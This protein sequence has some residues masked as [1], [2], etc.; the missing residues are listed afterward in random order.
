M[1]VSGVR[2]CVTA[3]RNHNSLLGSI[4]HSTILILFFFMAPLCKNNLKVGC[5]VCLFFF[6]V[7]LYQACMQTDT[8]THAHSLPCFIS[9]PLHCA[10]SPMMQQGPGMAYEGLGIAREACESHSALQTSTSKNLVA[11]R[12]RDSVSL[13]VPPPQ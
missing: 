5:P 8:H 10:Q 11:S 4:S 7:Y 3:D 12:W 2:M 9:E 13:E 6:F 1:H